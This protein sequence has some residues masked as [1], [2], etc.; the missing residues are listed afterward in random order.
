MFWGSWGATRLARG[1]G[2]NWYR[3]KEGTFLHLLEK[4][5]ALS[6]QYFRRYEF[7]NL[8]LFPYANG[9]L[10]K[11]KKT[12]KTWAIVDQSA[13]NLVWCLKMEEAFVLL[14]IAHKKNGTTCFDNLLLKWRLYG[15]FM[16]VR[17]LCKRS[18]ICDVA[19]H[20]SFIHLE[21][22]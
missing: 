20:S 7:F 8:F 11:I 1:W 10:I 21:M 9:I 13:W 14:T 18:F 4:S 17:K 15:K 16:T 3:V 12:S 19:G 2:W 22:A 5:R 6:D